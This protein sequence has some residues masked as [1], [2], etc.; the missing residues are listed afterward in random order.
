MRG[1]LSAQLRETDIVRIVTSE[2]RREWESK[3]VAKLVAHSEPYW[4][5]IYN[6]RPDTMVNAFDLE[7]RDGDGRGVA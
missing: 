3:E 2:W 1:H 7:L 4:T 6:K 5:Q